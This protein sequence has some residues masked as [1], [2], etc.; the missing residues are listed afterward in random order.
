MLVPETL[1]VV[2]AIKNWTRA[3]VLS[4]PGDQIDGILG[5]YFT[6][7]DILVVKMKRR[8]NGAR[9]KPRSFYILKQKY[10]MIKTADESS[11]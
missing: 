10:A 3:V 6:V 4:E 1:D 7:P 11:R 9:D 8:R 5:L 2:F